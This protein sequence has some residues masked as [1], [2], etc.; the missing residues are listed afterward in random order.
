MDKVYA[1]GCLS[2]LLPLSTNRGAERRIIE[3]ITV[4]DGESVTA[5]LSE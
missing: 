4:L 5:L 1:Q 3:I 2:A